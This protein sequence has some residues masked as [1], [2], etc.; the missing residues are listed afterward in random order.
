MFR[1]RQYTTI[2]LLERGLCL[3]SSLYGAFR[4]AVWC[5]RRGLH[6][7][8]KSPLPYEYILMLQV[9]TYVACELMP[10]WVC[11]CVHTRYVKS[12]FFRL[13]WSNATCHIDQIS[14][15]DG[16]LERPFRVVKNLG[17]WSLFTLSKIS[18]CFQSCYNNGI[19]SLTKPF[20]LK[21]WDF[22]FA[23]TELS[24]IQ[25]TLLVWQKLSK[26]KIQL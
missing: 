6:N 16:H 18:D 4:E 21:I 22:T 23:T 26:L 15:L 8:I 10:P 2:C 5:R 17:L 19:F 20:K 14:L 24:K 11:V 25:F 13:L 3:L 12:N 7:G 9:W 1:F